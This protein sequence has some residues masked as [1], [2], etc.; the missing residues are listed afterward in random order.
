[1]AAL[2]CQWW[3][4]ARLEAASTEKARNRGL[5]LENG[6]IF[7]T[8]RLTPR[9][10]CLVR[11]RSAASRESRRRH[12]ASYVQTTQHEGLMGLT[13]AP[14]SP[15]SY[16]EAEPSD[17]A[18]HSPSHLW[19]SIIPGMALFHPHSPLP[20]RRKPEA[21]ATQKFPC[22]AGRHNI[23]NCCYSIFPYAFQSLLRGGGWR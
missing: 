18:A 17:P 11:A 10:Y 19:D 16:V 9:G 6:M 3:V 5:H 1:M 8:G 15:A 13:P 4:M 2:R 7:I 23:T 12:H 20:S 21:S 14:L 22:P